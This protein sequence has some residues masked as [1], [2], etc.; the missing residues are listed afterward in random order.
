MFRAVA[1]PIGVLAV[2]LA[3]AA[4]VAPALHAAP[5]ERA[6]SVPRAIASAVATQSAS[7]PRPAPSGPCARAPGEEL[8]RSDRHSKLQM[9]VRTARTPAE[10][11][12][13][14]AFY[15]S[16]FPALAAV[17]RLPTDPDELQD[18]WTFVGQ[19]A[20]WAT[21]ADDQYVVLADRP[22]PLG[23]DQRR[24][25][26]PV[27]CAD[28]GDACDPDAG[29]WLMDAEDRLRTFSYHDALVDRLIDSPAGGRFSPSDADALTA[30][31]TE[32]LEVDDLASWESCVRNLVPLVTH[33]PRGE[34]L[35]PARG[36]LRVH[37][38]G[39]WEGCAQVTALALGSGLALRRIFCE[40]RSGSDSRVVVEAGRIG[41]QAA[42]RAALLVALAPYVTNSPAYSRSFA[43][44]PAIARHRRKA[45]WSRSRGFSTAADV[46]EVGYEL[47]GV[48]ASTTTGWAKVHEGAPP[49]QELLTSTL[50]S[51]VASLVRSC[52]SEA[53]RPE[54]ERLL[55]VLDDGGVRR[56]RASKDALLATLSCS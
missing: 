56:T 42:R 37:Q 5:P 27:L 7:L 30:C 1:L 38:L 52:L 11:E 25:L 17:R 35:L 53:D 24:A 32:A 18:W 3:C 10:V 26:S 29:A 2:T 49:V 51:L 48:L 50:E 55:S 14:R 54:I 45:Y 13:A 36:T 34:F 15:Q 16:W 47:S 46:H 23:A 31:E 20:S 28:E 9:L 8:D 39:Y 44:P 33:L 12:C 6:H 41:G 4:P 43:I 21:F 40:T 19:T 22:R